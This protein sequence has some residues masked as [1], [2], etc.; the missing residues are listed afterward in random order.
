MKFYYKKL[1]EIRTKKKIRVDAL[2]AQMEVGRTTIWA[3]ETGKRIPSER[4]IRQLADLLNISV[5][6]ISELKPDKAK[7]ETV[8]SSHI[9]S[10]LNA[11]TSTEINERQKY[12]KTHLKIIENQLNELNQISM[13]IKIFL[14]SI[15]TIFYSKDMTS[16][17]IFANRS[18]L[19]NASKIKD[20]KVL[21]CTDKDF[22]PKNEAKENNQED[23]NVIVNG[24]SIKREGYIPGNRKKKWGI[25][26]K[27]PIFDSNNRI[28]GILGYFHDITERKNAERMRELLDINVKMMTDAIMVYDYTNDK[29][30]YVNKAIENITGYTDEYFYKNGLKYWLSTGIHPDDKKKSYDFLN[31]NK[32]PKRAELRIITKDGKIRWIKAKVYKKVNFMNK[33]CSISKIQ[34]ITKRKR[35]ELI[36]KN[37]INS[38]EMLDVTIWMA[39]K[40]K[41]ISNGAVKFDDF[42]FIADNELVKRLKKEQDMTYNEL[43]EYIHSLIIN[44]EN[45]KTLDLNILKKYGFDNAAYDIMIPG[46][47]HPVHVNEKVFLDSESGLYIGI[48][49]IDKGRKKNEKLITSLRKHGIDE[50]II[51]EILSEVE[52]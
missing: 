37:L 24:Q 6:D 18:F 51:K 35:P 36:V 46:K 20:F 23:N 32:R 2:C 40:A 11:F 45:R 30:L 4:I 29:Y 50:K 28:L 25:I 13:I 17:Y 12:Q 52:I 22:F 39:R 41:V 19:D 31:N 10:L 21:G 5:E 15:D 47:K 9:D 49:E 7:N 26:S 42:L 34:D 43:Q 48:T 8:N 38:I 44:T 1:R 33:D 14:D 16:K 27:V 3:W